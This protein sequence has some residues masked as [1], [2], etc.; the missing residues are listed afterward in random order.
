VF[1]AVV[2]VPLMSF[3][4]SSVISI[5]DFGMRS[6]L[7]LQFPVLLL[8]SELLTA[9]KAP[10]KQMSAPLDCLGVAHATAGWVRAVASIALVLG[11]GGTIY[12]ALMFRFALPIVAAAQSAAHNPKAAYLGHNAYISSIGYARMNE[13]VPADFIVQYNPEEPTLFWENADLL[14]V[15]HQ[16]VISS[17]RGQCGAELGGDPSGCR[18]MAAAIDTLFKSASADTAQETCRRFG[19][20]ILIARVYDPVWSDERSWVWT[21][22]PVVADKE[23]RALTCSSR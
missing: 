19:I 6:A 16:T 11:V 14:G 12:Q 9:W 5:N 15:N 20:Q 1:I 23:F 10:S 17:E 13:V 3:L 2:T 7:L 4:R 21:L 8:G 22:K 18:Q